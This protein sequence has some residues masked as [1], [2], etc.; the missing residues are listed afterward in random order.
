M[1]SAKAPKDIAFAVASSR[2]AK[3]RRPGRPAAAKGPGLTRDRVV[4]AALELVAREGFEA[5]NVR[6]LAK[7]LGVWAG[8]VSHHAPSKDELMDEVADELLG[9][10]RVTFPERMDWRKRLRIVVRDLVQI[11]HENPG[12]ADWTVTRIN[13][14]RPRRHG[15]EVARV[16]LDTFV[17]AGLTQKEATAATVAAH[18]LTLGAIKLSDAARRVTMIQGEG[19]WPIATKKAW[20]ARTFS[21]N[22]VCEVCVD[23]IIAAVEA[24]LA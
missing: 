19:G 16:F 8:A 23:H 10:C 15:R 14:R 7:A 20:P 3:K 17:R 24:R 18:A 13:M 1:A 21:A 4:S 12:F 2:R 5:V 11:A 6:K 9:R 22:Q